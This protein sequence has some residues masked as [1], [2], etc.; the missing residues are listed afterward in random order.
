[1]K[2]PTLPLPFT[3]SKE[4]EKPS[5]SVSSDKSIT[6]RLLNR[7][8][9]VV[10]EADEKA[11]AARVQ[12]LK[13]AHPQA[14]TAVLAD[15]LIRNKSRDTGLIGGL[16]SAAALLPGL[17][18]VASLTFGVA[19]DISLTFKMQAEL[20]L[21]IASLYGRSMTDEEK[22][23]VVLMVTG[24]SAGTTAVVQR[25]GKSIAN[26]LSARFASKYLAKALPVVGM[27]FSASTNA[28]MTYA[29]GRRAQAYFSLP[30][31]E[32]HNWQTAAA[33]ITGINRE[34]G[35]TAVGGV[36]HALRKLG[37]YLPRRKAKQLPTTSQTIIPQFND[38]SK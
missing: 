15:R 17:G 11:A 24:A 8:A 10:D 32:M 13:N 6:G 3:S 33:A 35:Q 9:N 38:P 30:A 34:S 14:S 28:T 4:N 18:T 29:I 12:K 5:P 31:S 26:R 22:H 20:V 37:Q 23:R 7:F 2:V 19:A 36:K 1:M 25:A 16:T 21:E 27:L